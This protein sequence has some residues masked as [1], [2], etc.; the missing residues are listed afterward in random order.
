M[1]TYTLLIVDD[2]L[3]DV[4][5][6]STLLR[7][8]SATHNYSIFSVDSI[9]EAEALLSDTLFDCL[10]LSYSLLE[11]S[12]SL[13]FEELF[14]NQSLNPVPVIVLSLEH[15]QQEQAA[16]AKMGAFNYQ[17]KEACSSADALDQL[18]Q[19]AIYW[20]RLRSIQREV[21]YV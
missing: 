20:S 6:F 8:V 11:D 10:L 19:Q 4:E 21:S 12:P 18:I 13:P 16:A 9:K 17:V 5:E 14:G 7:N 2:C 15:S 1:R 3:E